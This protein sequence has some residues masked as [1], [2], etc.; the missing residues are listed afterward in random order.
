MEQPSYEPA[1]SQRKARSLE[2][3]LLEFRSIDQVV[4][5]PFQA[6]QPKRPATAHLP[7]TFPTQAHL[8]DYFTLFFTPDLFQ[9]I[10][11]NTNQYA[12]IQ[13]I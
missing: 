11:T 7:L 12:N 5:E 1:T 8:Y 10:T 3:I 9:S 4:Y 2:D 13:R 6:E